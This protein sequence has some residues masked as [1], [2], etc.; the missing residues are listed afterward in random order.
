[1]PKDFVTAPIFPPKKQTG[2]R[3]LM[4]RDVKWT[5]GVSEPNTE[6]TPSPAF[7]IRHGR[8]CFTLLSFRDPNKPDLS[9]KFSMNEFCKRYADTQGGRYSRDL[10]DVILN[11]RKTWICRTFPNGDMHKFTILGSVDIHEKI[12][13]TK[14]SQLVKQAELCLDRISL[15][16]DFFALLLYTARIRID[17]LN[18]ITS[19]LAQAIY[20]FIPSR[21]V[22]HK[23]DK[24]FEITA[25]NLLEQLGET[26]SPSKRTRRA[27]FANKRDGRI[28]IIDQLDG[29]ELVNGNLRVDIAET[30]D[31]SDWK[32]LF[33]VEKAKEI[34][35]PVP[36]KLH[37]R[38][39]GL[40]NL[41]LEYRGDK[42]SFDRLMKRKTPLNSYQEELLQ[43]AGID[44]TGSE[45][46]LIMAKTIISQG[47]F[48]MIL[49][50]IKN[51]V[52]EGQQKIDNP[53]KVLNYR[54][55]YAVK[56]PS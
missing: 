26:V 24:P 22:H 52:I 36:K 40:L 13:T 27:K 38:N 25:S 7:D 45:D 53:A 29:L 46:F 32:L 43:M 48:N 39:S 8:A 54:L 50:E 2:P 9:I 23:K 3:E 21:A 33:W 5:I 28:S 18:S 51:D 15:H 16:P 11:L 42:K 20:S 19:P 17:V 37:S 1:M 12:P 47:H 4:I 41:Y 31:K 34:V 10:L 49:A 55:R 35:L 14:S 6:Q 44:Y 30:T 56:N